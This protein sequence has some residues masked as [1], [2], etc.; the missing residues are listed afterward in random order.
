MHVLLEMLNEIIRIGGTTAI[1]SVMSEADFS[2]Y[3]LQ[4]EHHVLC[5]AAIDRN[6]IPLGFQSV[7]TRTDLPDGCCDIATFTDRSS[8]VKGVGT[9]LFTE[10]RKQ[11]IE[12]GFDTIN[13]TIR[14][15]NTAGLAYYSKMGF[16]NVEVHT[17]VPLQ[18]GTPV[19]RIS[20]RFTMQ[21]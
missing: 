21:Q 13:A 7:E 2:D 12:L 3:F 6:G 14:A 10:T 1:E 4:S 9:A 17:A 8:T 18:N 15:D 5:N 11:L 16:K 20:K 19:D